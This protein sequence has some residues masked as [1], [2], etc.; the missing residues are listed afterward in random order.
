MKEIDKYIKEIDKYI[1]NKDYDEALKLCN[2]VLKDIDSNNTQ[3]TFKAGYSCYKL[4]KYDIA[5]MYFTKTFQ[6]EKNDRNKAICKYYIGRC[7]DIYKSFE[8]ALKCFFEA[9]NL[10]HSNKYYTLWIG[11][12]YAKMSDIYY[13]NALM[14]LQMSLGSKDYLVYGYIG[15]CHFKLKNYDTAIMYLDKSVQLEY[16]NYMTRYYLGYAYFMIL[17]HNKALYNLNEAIKLKEDEFE[18]W[19][20]LGELYQ[21]IDDDEL[22]KECFKKARILAL[23]CENIEDAFKYLNKLV[24]VQNYEYLNYLYLG[25]CYIKMGN[26]KEAMTYLFEYINNINYCVNN[27]DNYLAFYWIGYLFYIQNEY[28]NAIKYFEKS[29]KL[30]SNNDA[31]ILLLLGKSYFMLG[32]NKKALYN[33][34]KSI[35]LKSDEPQTYELIS[36]VY[37]KLNQKNKFNLYKQLSNKQEKYYVNVYNDYK[38]ISSNEINEILIQKKFKNNIKN[39]YNEALGFSFKNI[40]LDDNYFNA[41]KLNIYY[42]INFLFQDITQSDLYNLYSSNTKKLNVLN[43]YNFNIYNFSYYNKILSKAL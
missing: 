36:K 14:Y 12:T 30:N 5:I 42:F 33:L 20:V 17:E 39:I 43:F 37:K 22:S 3:I 32:N 24:I 1:E 9:Y 40:V 7:Y 27:A 19:F 18:S 38:N 31:Y 34:K 26:Y 13:N 4:N 41:K 15:Y 23:N 8:E 35:K 6:I 2:S 21:S 28:E 25:I 10:D 29:I 16:N 11:I